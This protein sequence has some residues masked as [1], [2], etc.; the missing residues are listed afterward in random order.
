MPDNKA[1][2]FLESYLK[3]LPV[4]RKAIFEKKEYDVWSLGADKLLNLVLE[5]KK[6]ATAGLLADHDTVPVV[7]SLGIITDSQDKP[8][9]IVAYTDIQIRPFMEVNFEFAQA[10]GE[11]F[12]DI[13]EWRAEHRKVFKEWSGNSFTDDT[14]ILCEKFKLIYSV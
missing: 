3:N 1:Q 10:E 13:E 7:G 5:S 9:C 4:E 6:T 12:K 2:S 11:G 14:L 8:R